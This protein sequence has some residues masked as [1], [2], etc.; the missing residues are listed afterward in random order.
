MLF[1]TTV[2]QRKAIVRSKTRLNGAPG[3]LRIKLF[4]DRRVPAVQ[5]FSDIIVARRHTPYNPGRRVIHYMGKH[6]PHPQ[7]SLWSPDSPI[8]QDRHLFKMTTLDIDAFKYYYGVARADLDPKVWEILSHAGLL[9]PPYEKINYML[10]MPIFDK[11][12]LYRYYLRKRPSVE[13]LERRDYLDYSN[14]MV[15]TPEERAAR[16]PQEPWL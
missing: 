10:P 13:E 11:S 2:L 8:P 15:R 16:M 6:V 7:K 4:S 1:P 3:P 14:G 12:S 5:R 9:P